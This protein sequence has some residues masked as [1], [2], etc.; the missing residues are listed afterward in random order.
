MSLTA[1]SEIPYLVRSVKDVNNRTASCSLENSPVD[2]FENE[3]YH[4]C[5]VL[6]PAREGAPLPCGNAIFLKP[7][8]V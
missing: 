4:C 2:C 3:V 5:A 6:S 1:V 8:R 7:F